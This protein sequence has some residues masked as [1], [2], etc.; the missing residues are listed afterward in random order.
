M[1][2]FIKS[3]EIT[4]HSFMHFCFHVFLSFCFHNQNFEKNFEMFIL[5]NTELNLAVV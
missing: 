2:F 5:E 4:K 3:L 1:R